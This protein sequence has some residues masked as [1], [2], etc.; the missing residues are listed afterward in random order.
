MAE[1]H[2]GLGEKISIWV[3]KLFGVAT[4]N[5]TKYTT[6]KVDEN[7]GRLIDMVQGDTMI[8]PEG[9]ELITKYIKDKHIT[10]GIMGFLMFFQIL[11]SELTGTMGYV[12][13]QG[14]YLTNEMFRPEIPDIDTILINY[15]RGN[16][17]KGD[18]EAF[19]AKL[20]Y[21]KALQDILIATKKPLLDSGNISTS[22]IRQ[23]ISRK[24]FDT[25]LNKYGFDELDTS[26]I[27]Q[28]LWYYPSASDL[29]RFAVREVFSNDIIAKYRTD[30]DYPNEL[31]GYLAKA[32]LKEDWA[33]AYWREHWILPS[34]QQGFEMMHRKLITE[35][36]MSTL[37]RTLDIMP[38]WRDKIIKMSYNIPARV[39]VRRIYQLGL[40]DKAWVYEQ[41]E[42]EGYSPDDAEALTAFAVRGASETEK[43]L[44]KAEVVDGYKRAM[45]TKEE[46][47]TFL[48]NM[49][50]DAD[51]SAFLLSKVDM[52][53][54]KEAQD[55]EL[56][57]IKVKY[58]KG[59][60]TRDDAYAAL[61]KLNLKSTELDYYLMLWYKEKQANVKLPSKADL[62]KFIHYM[63]I[64]K[65]EYAASMLDMGYKQEDV[66]KY[67]KLLDKGVE[68]AP[69]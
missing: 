68:P 54:A 55:Q 27:E 24:D 15:Y 4:D 25:F 29:I 8:T 41:Y 45:L 2:P 7:S 64:T 67:V 30:E 65:E 37:L 52:D 34:P 48:T 6:T 18:V 38:Y 17:S 57:I 10:S 56:N 33:H 40:K 60:I 49:G 35:A 28:N 14:E 50:Y 23:F 22:Y 26:L 42:K 44:T 47:M 39:D 59:A 13:R 63:I 19:A 11:M 66:D 51:E 3:N 58:Q 53:N 31:T 43:D 46:T 1:T 16:F 21:S 12:K 36:D 9:K 5:V 20:G 32:G 69:D 61:N 62:A